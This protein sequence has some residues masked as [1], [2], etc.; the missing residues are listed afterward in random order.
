MRSLLLL[1]N[2]ILTLVALLL[3]KHMFNLTSEETDDPTAS[4][5]NPRLMETI[6]RTRVKR[7]KDTLKNGTL[8]IEE[9]NL[10][11]KENLFHPERI[12]IEQVKDIKIKDEKEAIEHFE[13]V[14]IAQIGTTS[15]ASIRVITAQNQNRRRRNIRNR[16]KRT[17]NSRQ[18]RRRNGRR[19]SRKSQVPA[20]NQ[21]IYP[22]HAPIGE[23]GFK[24]E[25][26]GID[27]VVLGKG[28][29]K[30]R[31][32]LDKGDEASNSRREKATEGRKEKGSPPER[33]K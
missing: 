13:L 31:L 4:I 7:D 9:T 10:I 21:K 3:T 2:A 24:L 1:V 25:Q 23:T 12:W 32:S 20:D 15:C 30:I 27:F 6:N 26:I 5:S 33:K 29:Q 16:R 14:S 8:G 22:L 11:W 17:R 18:S 19:S 28:E